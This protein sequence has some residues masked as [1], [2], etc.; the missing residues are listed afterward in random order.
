MKTR[1]SVVALCLFLVTGLARA[2]DVSAQAAADVSSSDLSGYIRGLSGADCITVGSDTYALATRYSTKPD[3]FT[4]A[5]WIYQGFS[6]LGLSTSYHDVSSYP[7][8]ADDVV[9]EIPGLVSPERIYI[10]CAHYD[11]TSP[12]PDHAPGADDDAS[13]TAAVLELAKVL[14]SYSFKSTIRF[15]AFSGE[16][17]GLRGSYDYARDAYNA[18]DDIRGVLNL[19]MIAYTGG[20]LEDIDIM[21]QYDGG[22]VLGLAAQALAESYR[23]N[24][25]DY[26]GLDASRVELHADDIGGSD[27]VSFRDRGY[28]AIM[29]IEDTANEIWGGSNPYYH[30]T[31]DVYANL[32]M[33]FATAVTRAAAATMADWAEPV[34]EPATLT[35]LAT[36]LLGAV[37]VLRRRGR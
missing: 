1:L 31:N 2:V 15:V 32:D 9:A 35:L 19:D 34:P 18:G 29:A 36:G 21:Y 23:D 26:S 28:A 7:T 27:H 37:G 12:D 33:D 22:S 11:S 3:A 17:Q 6:G 5:A 25:V 20:T 16:E 13:G 8:Y 30:T 4:A 10:V 24:F 14:S